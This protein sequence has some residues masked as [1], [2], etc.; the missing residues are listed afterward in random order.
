[1]NLKNHTSEVDAHTSLSKIEK[2][3]VEAGA[4]SIQ[5]LYANKECTGVSFGMRVNDRF[6]TFLLTAKTKEVYEHLLNQRQRREQRTLEACQ[7]QA[8][9]T[10]WKIIS[11]WVDI[12]LAMIQLEQVEPL[13]AFF[14]YLHD[15]QTSFYEKLKN[16]HFKLLGPG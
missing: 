13:Q 8:V 4:L 6:V 5:K 11:D 2:A 10:A 7:K 16:D 9:R 15:G 3:L 1:M 12:Q 14:P